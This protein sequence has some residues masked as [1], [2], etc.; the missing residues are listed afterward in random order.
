MGNGVVLDLCGGSGGWSKPYFEATFNPCDY[1]DPYTKRTALWGDFNIPGSCPVEPMRV[2]GGHH[3]MD[4]YLLKKYGKIPRS[5][6]AAIRAQTP[7][8]F[9]RCF[10]EANH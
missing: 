1:G 4:A 8:G 5:V 3:S 7:P 2:E 6:R 9:A 10:F